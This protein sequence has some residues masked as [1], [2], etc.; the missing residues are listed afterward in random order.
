MTGHG[1]VPPIDHELHFSLEPF[2]L[3]RDT[4]EEHGSLRGEIDQKQVGL[5]AFK[6]LNEIRPALNFR[7]G[8]QER[9]ED[10]VNR[11]LETDD[12]Q[13]GETTACDYSCSV[14]PVF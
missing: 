3:G 7:H 14:I 11:R 12:R 10:A 4:L 9:Y 13:N 8:V 5:G 6:F 2:L 1:H